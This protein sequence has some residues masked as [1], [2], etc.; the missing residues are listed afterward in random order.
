MKLLA[1]QLRT[2]AARYAKI[3]RAANVK[4]D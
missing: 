1:A 2:D 3:A 4:V